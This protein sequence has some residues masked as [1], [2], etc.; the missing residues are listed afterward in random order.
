MI[1][2][3]RI[4]YQLL[5]SF[6]LYF[7]YTDIEPTNKYAMR[8]MRQTHRDCEMKRPNKTNGI[9]NDDVDDNDEMRATTKK[10]AKTD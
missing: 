5:F 3:I 10:T 7:L 2:R 1:S 9:T 6:L 8:N 4:T